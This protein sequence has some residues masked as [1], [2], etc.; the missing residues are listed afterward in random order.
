MPQVLAVL[1]IVSTVAGVAQSRKAQKKADQAA[2]LQREQQEV[3]ATASRRTAIRRGISNRARARAA[4]QALGASGS[5]AISGGLGSQQSQL[6]SAIGTQNQLSG[7][8]N[9]IGILQ[10]GAAR[11]QGLSNLFSSA[12]NLSINLGAGFGGDPDEEEGL[13]PIGNF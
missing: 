9:Q 1:A 5:S 11:A 10:S 7:L 4:A 3:Q 13:G 8:S 6:F 12:A 2:E